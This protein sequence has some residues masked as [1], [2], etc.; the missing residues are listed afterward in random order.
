VVSDFDLLGFLFMHILI[1]NDETLEYLTS[2]RTWTKN[3]LAGQ[4]FPNKRGALQ[5]AKLEAIG[6]FN[7]VL[8]LPDNHQFVNLERGRG[9]GLPDTAIEG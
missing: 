1:E 6:R 8:Y 3:P 2:D 7:I 9:K 5:A 4:Q